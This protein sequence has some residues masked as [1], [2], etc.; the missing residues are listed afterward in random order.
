M[1]ARVDDSLYQ[2]EVEELTEFV[3]NDEGWADLRNIL[4]EKQFDIPNTWLAAF[5]EDEDEMEY[6]VLVTREKKVF[7]YSRSTAD[8]KNNASNFSFNELTDLN[9]TL[10]KH[11]QVKVAF[12][13]IEKRS[14]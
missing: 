2:Q 11:P 14:D 4:I 1:M 9:S 6:G 7:E 5:A 3:R 13:M 8:G 12:R 10:N